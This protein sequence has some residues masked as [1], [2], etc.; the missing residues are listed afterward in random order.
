MTEPRDLE[1]KER[2]LSVFKEGGCYHSRMLGPPA[3]N[4]RLGIST[5]DPPVAF[6]TAVRFAIEYAK[7]QGDLF[8]DIYVQSTIRD[9]LEAHGTDGQSCPRGIIERIITYLKYPTTSEIDRL[10]GEI[11][12]H[13]EEI[14]KNKGNA[15]IKKRAEEYIETKEKL[16]KEY[17]DILSIIN[18]DPAGLV[19]IYQQSWLKEHAPDKGDQAFAKS[20]T[21]GGSQELLKTSDELKESYLNYLKDKFKIRDTFDHPKNKRLKDII[22]DDS[23]VGV[24]VLGVLADADM[25]FFGGRRPNKN[26]KNNKNT[27]KYKN[28]HRSKTS[29]HKTKYRYRH[30]HR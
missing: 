2:Y 4:F 8:Q 27:H 14:A 7:K 10:E 26:N 6:G 15:E 3:F 30:M 16:I 20:P 23:V 9:S 12:E 13:K 19:G 5:T 29:K 21:P 1:L 22:M 28:N 11:R 24:N 17:K 18:S 25:L